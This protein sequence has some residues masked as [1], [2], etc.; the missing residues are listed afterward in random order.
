MDSLHGRNRSLRAIISGQ[1]NRSRVMK[2][3]AVEISKLLS[4]DFATRPVTML[5]LSSQRSKDWILTKGYSRKISARARL[6]VKV[7]K[8]VYA[9]SDHERSAIDPIG[10][11]LSP[12]ASHH[13]P[14]IIGLASRVRQ[15]EPRESALAPCRRP[16]PFFTCL[17]ILQNFTTS[18]RSPNRVRN[19][20]LPAAYRRNTFVS[21]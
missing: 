8:S 10:P 20:F 7:H 6:I 15:A 21:V 4:L 17:S 5:F 1:S 2:N 14:F 12:H 19:S 9:V 16:L 13:P 11:K 3:D 18:Q